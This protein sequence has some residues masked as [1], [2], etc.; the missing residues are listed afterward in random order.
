MATDFWFGLPPVGQFANT[1]YDPGGIHKLENQALNRSTETNAEAETCLALRRRP[2][3][4]S[5]E[6]QHNEKN[7]TTKTER[8]SG[9]AAVTTTL[10]KSYCLAKRWRPL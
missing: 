2:G 4:P 1:N 7:Q 6:R 8:L 3:K 10:G 5:R 9:A